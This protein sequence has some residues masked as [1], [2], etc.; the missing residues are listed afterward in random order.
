MITLHQK[1]IKRKSHGLHVHDLLCWSQNVDQWQVHSHNQDVHLVLIGCVDHK[2]WINDSFIRNINYFDVSTTTLNIFRTMTKRMVKYNVNLICD[3]VLLFYTSFRQKF[4]IRSKVLM[5]I[6]R[7]RHNNKYSLENYTFWIF[8]WNFLV[9]E[10]WIGVVNKVQ[11]S[12]W[13]CLFIFNFNSCFR[14]IAHCS[15]DCL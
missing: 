13:T 7:W 3:L 1:D 15:T 6:L 14:T 10:I 9:V 12:F 4:W 5:M 11:I 8:L 2:I